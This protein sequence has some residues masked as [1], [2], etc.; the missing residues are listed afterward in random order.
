M[1]EG[2]LP[3]QLKHARNHARLSHFPAADLQMR[4]ISN[5]SPPNPHPRIL[6]PQVLHDTTLVRRG[7]NLSRGKGLFIAAGVLRYH[8]PN[9][10]QNQSTCGT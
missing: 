5:L 8:G 6:I 9:P 7:P 1:H 2:G 10:P 3:I 4:I